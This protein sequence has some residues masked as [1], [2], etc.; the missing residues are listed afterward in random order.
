MKKY[1]V[2]LF[3]TVMVLLVAAVYSYLW[4]TRLNTEYVF[5]DEVQKQ[6]VI[7]KEGLRL[8]TVPHIV[9]KSESLWVIAREY[10]PEDDPRKVIY[11]IMLANGLDDT[12]LHPGQIIEVP[13]VRK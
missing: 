13:G 10:R 3:L 5:A 2:F 11:E 7:V 6:T 8:K 9:E 1:R 4:L 12:V